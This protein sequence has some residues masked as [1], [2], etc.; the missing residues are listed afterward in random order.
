MEK[1]R[2]GERESGEFMKL[3]KSARENIDLCKALG[4]MIIFDKQNGEKECKKIN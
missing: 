2:E 1:E 3:W 4:M